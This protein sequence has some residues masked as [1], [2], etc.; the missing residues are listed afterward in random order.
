VDDEYDL[1]AVADQGGHALQGVAGHCAAGAAA[2]D[3][4]W[5]ALGC[6]GSGGPVPLSAHPLAVSK[7][8]CRA[9]A[10]EGWLTAVRSI[11]LM[12]RV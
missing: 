3:G 11:A 9:W 12:V 1:D 10:G 4:D 5:D 7:A 2:G 8:W 6:I